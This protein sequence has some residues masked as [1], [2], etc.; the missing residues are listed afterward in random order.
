MA[1][2]MLAMAPRVRLPRIRFSLTRFKGPGPSRWGI[3]VG[4]LADIAMW[5]SCST[6][7]KAV[8]EELLLEA[9]L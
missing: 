5:Y 4:Y 6:C 8:C 7:L 9:R 2:W 3:D 1:V